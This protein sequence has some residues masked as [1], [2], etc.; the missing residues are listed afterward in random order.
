MRW[1]IV[2]TLFGKEAQRLRVNRGSLALAGLL[3][4]AAVLLNFYS[5]DGSPG[6]ALSG[7][8]ESCYVDYWQQDA[9]L[10]HLRHNVPSEL[11]RHIHFRNINYVALP[12]EILVYPQGSGAIQLRPIREQNRGTKIRIMLWEPSRG[13]LAVFE[14]WFWRES[15]RFFQMQAAQARRNTL[16]DRSKSLLSSGAVGQPFLAEPAFEQ[17]NAQ[18]KGG[19]DMRA[20]IASGLVLFALF[21]SC[22]YLMPSLMCEERERGLLLAQALSPASALEIL[23]AK[24]LFYPLIGLALAAA[25]AG[26]VQP[27]VLLQPFFW[28]VLVVAAF[29]SLGVGLTIASWARNQRAAS[30]GALGYM[31]AVT[32]LL[33]ICQQG[34]IQGLPY[35]ALE[36]HCPRMLHACL[37]GSVQWFHWFNLAA[38][39]GLALVWGALATYLFR[40]RGWQ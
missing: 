13:S 20:T 30:M 38:A 32:L 18:L 21:F 35:L 6:G 9:W 17:E 25:L 12:D 5:V 3:V 34:G 40:K 28:L 33:F 15:A 29:G 4:V 31:M 22:V 11:E 24:F 36:Y 14:A 8:V 27:L 1:H 7:G 23:A 10:D 16:T 26:I 39:A 2:R 37:A 19:L